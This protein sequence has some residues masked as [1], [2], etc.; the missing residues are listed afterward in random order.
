MRLI[1]TGARGLLGHAL[2]NTF[3]DWE[4]CAPTSEQVDI[5]QAD[6]VDAL[7]SDIRPHVVIH[8]AALTRVDEC[9][10]G[11]ERAYLVNAHGTENVARACARYGARLITISTDYVFSGDSEQPYGEEH[12]PGPRNVYGASKLAAE[13]ATAS[14]C[15]DNFA[16]ARVSWLFGPGRPSFVDSLVDWGRAPETTPVRVV[17]DQRSAP[18]STRSVAW[19]LRDIATSD[20]M[21]IL[22]LTNRGGASRHELAR[23]VF[24]ILGLARPM[25][26][27]TSME[28]PTPARRPKN[29]QLVSSRLEPLGLPPMP[30]WRTELADY[31]L[32]TYKNG[33]S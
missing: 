6:Q 12:A 26:P 10:M 25:E 22:H 27:C 32:D 16:I 17:A 31:L 9:E 11:P 1:I 8:S 29:S 14:L 23:A 15:P 24:D 18:T 28:V 21:G 13:W 5:T 19:A 4:V 30:E 7:V 2:I 3:H 33:V 20:C